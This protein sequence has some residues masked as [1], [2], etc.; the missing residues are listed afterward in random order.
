MKQKVYFWS[1]AIGLLVVATVVGFLYLY[2]NANNSDI[3]QQEHVLGSLSRIKQ[4]DANWDAHVLKSWIGMHRD[5]DVVSSSVKEMQGAMEELKVEIKPFLSNEAQLAMHDLEKLLK[6]KTD[7]TERFKRRNSVLKNSLRYLPTAQAEV[8]ALMSGSADAKSK[9]N[10]DQHDSIDQLVSL[11][12]QY[13]LFPEDKLAAAVQLQNDSV[14]LSMGSFAPAV[15]EK[16]GNLVK[17]VDVVLSERVGIAV[18][19]GK[20]DYTPVGEQLDILAAEVAKGGLSDATNNSRFS[21]YLQY[22]GIAVVVLFLIL[23]SV[24]ANA[25]VRLGTR[26]AA[27]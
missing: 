20:I 18:M 24:L 12:L 7:L 23:S 16:V 17:H 26:G 8:R 10:T 25:V 1:V 19:I 2:K 27:A 13:N 14:R 9:T 5:Y 11:V 21:R 6:E 4:L 3:V 22:Y 15:S